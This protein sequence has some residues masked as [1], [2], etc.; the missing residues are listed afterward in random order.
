MFTHSN[1]EELYD[2][3]HADGHAKLEEILEG[4]TITATLTPLEIGRLF[5]KAQAIK[6]TQTFDDF[7]REVDLTKAQLAEDYNISVERLTA[8]NE[9]GLNDCDKKMLAFAVL[10]D[11]VYRWRHHICD[12]CGAEFFDAN[13]DAHLCDAC[14]QE[15]LKEHL[16]C[17]K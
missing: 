13:P 2:G 10:S 3:S 14:Y 11:L 9:A 4:E 5:T 6:A 7:L 17:Y 1:F 15:L 16:K 8:W 12:T